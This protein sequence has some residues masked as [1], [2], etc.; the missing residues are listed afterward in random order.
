[1]AYLIKALKL[2]RI[3][4]AWNWGYKQEFLVMYDCIK[5]LKS[6]GIKA[7]NILWLVYR[8]YF[9]GHYDCCLQCLLLLARF[10]RCNPA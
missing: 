4:L 5:L 6:I 3:Y 1:M 10:L 7:K 9:P 8:V 2:K